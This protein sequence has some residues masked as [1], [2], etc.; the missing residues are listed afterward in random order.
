MPYRALTSLDE[1]QSY[2]DGVVI[3]EGDDGGQVY[4]VSPAAMVRC[5][6]EA[7][8]DLLRDLDKIAWPHNPPDMARVFFERHEVGEPIW[9]GMGGATVIADIWIHPEF[10]EAGLQGA[11]RAVIEGQ[12]LRM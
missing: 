2:S 7:L 1:A 12:R 10:V 6:D 4:V 11:I 9:G 8:E 5:S 3:L